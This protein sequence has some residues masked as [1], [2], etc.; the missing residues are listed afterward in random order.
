VQIIHRLAHITTQ[1]ELSEISV[2]M[3]PVGL[4][5]HIY[6]DERSPLM[7]NF[8]QTKQPLQK[9]KEER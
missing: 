9:K 2:G 4:F 8:V 6:L 3:A 5:G 7:Y 1:I